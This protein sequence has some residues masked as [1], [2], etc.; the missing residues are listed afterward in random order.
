MKYVKDHGLTW[1]MIL[2]DAR[3]V[4]PALP[5]NFRRNKFNM[6]EQKY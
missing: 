6:F 4:Y 3:D 5:F 2:N 1:K